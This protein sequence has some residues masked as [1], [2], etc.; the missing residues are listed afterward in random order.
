MVV[1]AVIRVGV[2]LSRR[3]PLRCFIG[4]ARLQTHARF[5][6][7]FEAR[8]RARF[9]ARFGA[10]FGARFEARRRARFR[11][12][13]RARRRAR[14]RARFRA[15][16]RARRR[17]WWFRAWRR[18]RAG[19]KHP[20][21]RREGRRS[22]RRDLYAH[23]HR[24]GCFGCRLAYFESSAGHI[25]VAHKAELGVFDGVVDSKLPG[26]V[27]AKFLGLVQDRAEVVAAALGAPL[28]VERGNIVAGLGFEGEGTIGV[29]RIRVHARAVM[30]RR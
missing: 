16:F 10:R 25:P 24:R 18:A 1:V 6:A 8:R 15:R 29:A 4:A 13:F 17:A 14:R 21:S 27:A 3:R 23:G 26:H 19:K 9:R 7:R 11:A 30:I 28:Y 12:R 2:R 22:L 5:G 20:R